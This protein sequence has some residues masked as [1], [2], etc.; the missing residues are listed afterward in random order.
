M[1]RDIQNS[2]A[3]GVRCGLLLAGSALALAVLMAVFAYT[4]TADSTEGGQAV[5]ASTL[6]D[7]PV[8]R[9]LLAAANRRAPKLVAD[10]NPSQRVG[11]LAFG[12]SV[13][14]S[15]E[16]ASDPEPNQDEP[17]PPTPTAPLPP[18]STAAPTIAATTVP[19]APPP[20]AV[21]L[22]SGELYER[23]AEAFPEAPERAYAVA[24]CESS[25][26][27]AT[28]TGNGYYG[29]WQFDL[30]TWQSVGGSG[31]PSDASVDEQIS[32]ARILYENRGWSPWGCS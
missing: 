20:V 16:A 3:R 9:H 24:M 13:E 22:P 29:L 10:A 27:A 19:A 8:D 5:A 18:A 12:L 11:D 31:L 30:P 28:N 4:A 17:V 21:I 26:N 2:F 25:G 7:A 6:P 1:R 32:R 15:S 14:S 23:I